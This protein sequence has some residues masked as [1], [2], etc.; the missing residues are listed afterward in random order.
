MTRWTSSTLLLAAFISGLLAAAAASAADTP[1]HE[2]IELL[3]D[4]APEALAHAETIY[5]ELTKDGASSVK[6]AYALA[7]LCTREQKFDRAVELLGALPNEAKRTLPVLRLRLWLALEREEQEMAQRVLALAL[8]HCN[9]AELAESERL[10][11]VRLLGGIAGAIPAGDAATL[12]A[13]SITSIVK[14]FSDPTDQKSSGVFRSA[15]QSASK[16]RR[17]LGDLVAELKRDQEAGV[18]RLKEAETEREKV[19]KSRTDAEAALTAKIADNREA[20]K[21]RA[22]Q[23]REFSRQSKT[24]KDQWN[25]ETPG[26]PRAPRP[27]TNP[28]P[29]P[30]PDKEGR[31]GLQEKIEHRRDVAEYEKYLREAREFPA[32]LA[33]WRQKDEARRT[34]LLQQ[35][36]A[37]DA[38]VTEA[39]DATLARTAEVDQL[40]REIAAQQAA[41]R[42]LEVKVRLLRAVTVA[43]GAGE[44]REVLNRPSAYDLLSIPAE[45]QRLRNANSLR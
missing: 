18:G 17:Q 11:T 3:D 20:E 10:E 1:L 5:G 37:L 30:R 45:R 6:G 36:A 14:T 41:A 22:S 39:K 15:Q 4:P 8:E 33:N 40:R 16:R 12:P 7:L 9:H 38:Q 2:L 35:R 28:G 34:D 27:V 23:A 21:E 42:D 43:E 25:T 13:A 26:R 29:I 44:G 31:T 19:A 32:K 24:I